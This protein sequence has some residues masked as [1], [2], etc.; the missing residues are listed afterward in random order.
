MSK[1]INNSEYRKQGIKDILKMLHEGKS[2]EEAKAHFSKVFDQV[3]AKEISEAEQ[4]LISEGLPVEEVQKLCDVHSA[5]FKGSIAE[6]HAMPES[7]KPGHPVWVMKRE[8]TAI[9]KVVNEQMLPALQLAEKD[10]KAGSVQ[11]KAALTLLATVKV[12][13]QRK[14]N[15]LFPYLERYGIS[16]PPKVM[17]SV[18][19]DI[20]RDISAASGALDK[21]V[22]S[23]EL[24][25]LV[26]KAADG[27]TE[28][29]FKENNILLPMLLETLTAEEWVKINEEFP[30]LG[31]TLIDEPPL[32][33]PKTKVEA[34]QVGINKTSDTA[35]GLVSLPTGTLSIK[36]LE[37]I[38]N[39]LPIDISFVN[40]DGDLKYFSENAERI[41]PRT[42]AVL[43]RKVVNC[44]PPAS[45]HVVE[46]IIS[47]FETGKKDEE[48]FWIK[49]GE[50]YVYIRYFA[51]RSPEGEYLGTVEVTQNITPIQAINGEK[52]LLS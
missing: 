26:K 4:A 48:S 11:L 12:H 17:W 31:Y 46:Q 10:F 47:D 33:T 23:E 15:I 2:L 16:G 5:V 36:E 32:W 27:V 34:T 19:D 45:M 38:L 21:G 50:S 37:S 13:Y 41:F 9:E 14:E 40:K 24:G 20:R 51:A 30:S 29:V 49:M 1:E 18:D 28:M 52:R 3:S 35:E 43:G 8:N 22:F 25:T 7:E 44:H 39:T 6:I 42:K